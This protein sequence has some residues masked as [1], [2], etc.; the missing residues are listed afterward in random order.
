MDD[1]SDRKLPEVGELIL[2][3]LGVRGVLKGAPNI[4]T[5][6][7][8]VESLSSAPDIVCVLWNNGVISHTHPKNWDMCVVSQ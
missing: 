6:G 7:L 5:V 2:C 4:G 1:G 3:G 8:V